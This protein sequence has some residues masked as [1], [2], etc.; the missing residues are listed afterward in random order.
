MDNEHESWKDIVWNI[1][2]DD[3]YNQLNASLQFTYDCTPFFINESSAI[4]MLKQLDN[5]D[6]IVNNMSEYPDALEMIN[7]CKK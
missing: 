2:T 6:K 7:K 3:L 1:N 5:A 4:D